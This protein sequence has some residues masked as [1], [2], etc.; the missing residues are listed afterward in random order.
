MKNQKNNQLGILAAMVGSL[1]VASS[2]PTYGVAVVDTV[3]APSGYFCPTDAAK[4]DSPYYRYQGADWGWTHNAAPF[5][6]VTINS[7]TLN[8]SAFD[9][10]WAQ[11]EVDNIYAYDNGVKTLLGSLTG[12]NDQWSY[13]TFTLGSV[14]YDDILNGLQVWMQIDA[15]SGS[16][17]V[18]LSKSVLEV[19]GGT[20]P[21]PT[22]G[23]PD[24][25][26][27]MLLLGA[28]A[29]VIGAIKR[30]WSK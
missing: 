14:F 13:A 25:G 10:D 8:I 3:Q 4:Y 18:T 7:A 1:L 29:M 16:W 22:P 28:S 30:R 12:Q 26:S 2:Y 9:V 5:S 15:N 19:N 21:N 20:L 6:G 17:A 27:T 11:G 23:V 24:G